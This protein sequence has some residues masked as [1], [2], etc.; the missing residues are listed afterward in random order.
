MS[1]IIQGSELFAPA[2]SGKLTRVVADAIFGLFRR[3]V[4]HGVGGRGGNGSPGSGERRL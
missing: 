1:G 2:S 4:T 3:P